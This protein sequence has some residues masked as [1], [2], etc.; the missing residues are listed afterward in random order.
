MQSFEDNWIKTNSSFPDEIVNTNE[1]SL[2]INSG[3]D[4]FVE[5][6]DMPNRGKAVFA[7]KNHPNWIAFIPNSEWIW[8]SYKITDPL[9]DQTCCFTHE[10]KFLGIQ[11]MGH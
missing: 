1:L 4:T 8:D 10:L 6:P 5:G 9:I 3:T 2:Y 7:W 11:L